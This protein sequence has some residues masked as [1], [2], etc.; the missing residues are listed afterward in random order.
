MESVEK[1]LISANNPHQTHLNSLSS[2]RL[3]KASGRQAQQ[4]EQPDWD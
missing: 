1:H 4:L 2:T 3:F